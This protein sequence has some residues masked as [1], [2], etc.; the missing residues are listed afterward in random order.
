M[1]TIQHHIVANPIENQYGFN[2]SICKYINAELVAGFTL[3]NFETREEQ[4]Q[5]AKDLGKILA[6]PLVSEEY[7]GI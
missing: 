4:L 3:N 2:V 7:E 1:T 6:L 5:Y